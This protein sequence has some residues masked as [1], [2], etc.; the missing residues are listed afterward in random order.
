MPKVYRRYRARFASDQV[1]ENPGA[2]D[3]E[4]DC[5]D[6]G[7]DVTDCRAA[8]EPG[9]SRCVPFLSMSVVLCDRKLALGALELRCAEQLI[10][11]DRT[12]S[13]FGIFFH[14]S[15]G[16][17]ALSKGGAT[18]SGWYAAFAL[19]RVGILIRHLTPPQRSY[20]S[21]HASHKRA[22]WRTYQTRPE[23]SLGSIF[24]KSAFAR[25]TS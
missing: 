24:S 20:S 25:A 22:G 21:R 1:C 15:L 13:I 10:A 6:R 7:T 4:I 8:V 3:C 16:C 12:A 2:H 9:E 11:L 23:P 19:T 18:S 14:R 5:H 17:A